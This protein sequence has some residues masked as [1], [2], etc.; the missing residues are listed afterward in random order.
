VSLDSV[1][2]HYIDSVS[3][4]NDF[5]HWLEQ[6]RPIL[7]VDT[8]TTGLKAW[9]DHVRLVQFGDHDDGW[10]FR[11]SRW[12]GVV[13]EVFNGYE[14]DYVFHNA[15]FDL[16]MLKR[17]CDIVIHTSRV[18]D[19]AI[20]ARILDPCG[21]R[22][23]KPLCE[24][25]IDRNAGVGQA[26]LEKA[27][28]NGNWDWATIPYEVPAYSTYAAMDTVLTVRL[29]E[30][31]YPQILSKCSNAYDLEREFAAVAQKI[32]AHGSLVDRDYTA[33][34]YEALTDYMKTAEQ[35]CLDKYNV[36][37]GSSQA[38]VN[39]LQNEG[40]SFVKATKKGAIALDADVLEGI[41]HPLAEVVL[42]R[43][44]TQKVANTYLRN[45][46]DMPDEHDIIRPGMDSQG[47]VTGRMSMELFQTLPR[48]NEVN[49]L[50][51]IVRNCIVPRE[52][53]VM[54]LCDWDQIEMRIL[55]HLSGDPGLADA[56]MHGDFFLNLTRE[57]FADETIQRNDPRRQTTKNGMYAWAYG[58]GA[59]KFARTAGIT[60]EAGA[61]FFNSI[62]Q[63]F[64]MMDGLK[65]QV[66]T[67]A[68]QRAQLEGRPYVL[69]PF[70]R[71]PY[72]PQ[73]NDK[74]YA[75]VNYLIQGSAASILKMK[76]VAMDNAGIGDFITLLVHDEV[77][78]DV[79]RDQ[80]QDVAVTMKDIMND[81]SLLS[82]P[83]TA[84][85]SLASRWGA[86]GDIQLEDV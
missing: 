36:K 28:H 45:F 15:K 42:Q 29:F 51:D 7:G 68:S 73:D 19:T 1:N 27:M 37:P 82:V 26:M 69:S 40:I 14:G 20:M 83:L 31:F 50:A 9:R 55:A 39:I 74:I 3:D 32:E 25:H 38:V 30:L 78:A 13:Q 12:G 35:W 76:V 79:P 24:I 77:I 22:A 72:Y 44:R 34:A 85:L 84:S 48:R 67:V 62:K 75:L 52:G 2:L 63:R 64:P 66:E 5:M 47:T 86:K 61:V 33:N 23:L 41:N 6:R 46:L 70:T 59:E 60:D 81:N 56:F 58:A 80:V 53:N 49:P 17:W 11:W 65:K 71:Q 54:M 57:I 43:R 18:H 16:G 21:P 8:E 4:A 10:T